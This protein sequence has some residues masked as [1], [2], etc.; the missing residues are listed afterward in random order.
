MVPRRRN[1]DP[2][3]VLFDPDFE[4]HLTAKQEINTQWLTVNV[5]R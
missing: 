3:N 1:I 5:K 4:E 2:S